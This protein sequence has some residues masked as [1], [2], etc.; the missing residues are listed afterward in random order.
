M[1]KTKERT[2]DE[3]VRTIIRCNHVSSMP[4][5]LDFGEELLFAIPISL[6]AVQEAGGRFGVK[7]FHSGSIFVV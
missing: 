2:G 4:D 3:R 7:N 1:K 6:G 5:S